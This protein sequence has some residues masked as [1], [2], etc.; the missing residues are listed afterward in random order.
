MYLPLTKIPPPITAPKPL[1]R[2]LLRREIRFLVLGDPEPFRVLIDRFNEATKTLNDIRLKGAE[3]RDM[4]LSHIDQVEKQ[5]QEDKTAAERMAKEKAHR[6]VQ[7]E[8]EARAE[9]CKMFAQAV[10]EQFNSAESQF[11]KWRQWN[12]KQG[13]KQGEA[14]LAS[15]VDWDSVGL[16][17]NWPPRST[18]I[19]RNWPPRSTVIRY[20]KRVL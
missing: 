9:T 8:A 12:L 2:Y 7:V 1:P 17:R 6:E 11:T 14:E 5:K 13:L 3:A 19:R 20:I 10:A 18:G 16:W 4:A 15:P